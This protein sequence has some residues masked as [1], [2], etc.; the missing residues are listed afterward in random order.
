M[1]PFYHRLP[2]IPSTTLTGLTKV[3]AVWKTQRCTSFAR[4]KCL[5]LTLT[6]ITALDLLP[7]AV[8][9][10][11]DMDSDVKIRFIGEQQNWD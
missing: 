10:F 5:M 4:T 7:D 1:K 2:S 6:C 8:L 9:W 3:G 11:K